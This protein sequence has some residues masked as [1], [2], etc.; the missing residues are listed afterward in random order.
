MFNF[1]AY[2]PQLWMYK[3][4]LLFIKPVSLV[5]EPGAHLLYIYIK[6]IDVSF[7]CVCPLIDDKFRH[8]IVKVL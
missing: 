3:L 8:N 7:L 2:H 4:P 1:T 6:Q 5:K